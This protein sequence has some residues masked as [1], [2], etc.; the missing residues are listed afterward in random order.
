MSFKY[1]QTFY[2]DSATVQGSIEAS[3]SGIGLYFRAKP[4]FKNNKS[5]IEGPG[6]EVSLVPV[7]GGIP[8]IQEVGTI[9][10]PEPTE[11]G[12]RFAPR[13]EVARKEWG[14]ITATADASVETKFVFDEPIQLKTKSEYGIVIK[15]DG[16]EDY[17]FWGSR[18]GNKLVGTTTVSP[19]ASN[20]YVG[21]LFDYISHPNLNINNLIPSADT[22]NNAAVINTQTNNIIPT[23]TADGKYSAQNWKP[24][25]DV[26]LKFKVYASRYFHNGYPVAANVTIQAD[27][28]YAD[29]FSSDLLPTLNGNVLTMVA[30]SIPQE[31][32]R[33]DVDNSVYH[34]IQAGDYVCQRLPYYPSTQKVPLT[35]SVNASSYVVTAN[36]SFLYSNGSTFNNANGFNNL[37]TQ[38]AADDE[39]I[40][41]EGV[42]D[43]TTVIDIRKVVGIIANSQILVDRPMSFTNGASKFWKSPVG[44]IAGLNS[45]YINGQDTAILILSDSNANGTLRFTNN[46]IE[47]SNIVAGG[48]GYSN[49]DYVT[50][51]GYESTTSVTGG[52]NA[53]LLLTT[54]STGG[55]VN[56]F[57]A[58]TGAGFVY[59]SRLVG[60][61]VVFSNSTGGTS[62]GSGANLQFNIGST[63]LAEKEPNFRAV[64]CAIINL[65]AARLKPEITVNN[66][67]GSTFVV[68]HRSL[69]YSQPNTSV[70]NGKDAFVYAAPSS[71]DISV[72]IF[73]SHD[74]GKEETYT[75]IVPSRSNEFI[76]PYANGSTANTSVIGQRYSNSSV[77]LFDVSANNDYLSPYIEPKII[78]SHYSKYVINN[79]YTNE[80]TNY[81]NA[82]AKH[83]TTKVNFNKDRSAEDILVYLTAYRPV[84]TDFK[85]Y[86][87]IHSNIDVDAFDDKD[88][89]LLE[90]IDGIGVYSSKSDSSDFIELTYNFQ[91]TANTTALAGSVTV[92]NVTTTTITG[93]GTNF[94]TSL[95]TKDLVKITNPLFSGNSYVFCVVNT[96]TNNTS[97][98]IN[99]P[100]SNTGLV[101]SGMQIGKVDYKFQ[102]F[103]NKLNSNI[104]QYFDSNMV[105]TQTYDTFQVKVV[106]LSNS[107]SIVPKIDDIRTIGVSA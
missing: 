90:Q 2:L 83:V 23:T 49:N 85:V 101:G 54:N 65:E 52:Y 37:Y 82:Y 104:V 15:V 41:I 45:T 96:V 69:F 78:H 47:S 20:K 22:S 42:I 57:V 34:Q 67:L 62:A 91:D 79:D 44:T 77:Y 11:H 14:E 93:S 80:H 28:K 72:K 25:A 55:I 3:I 75:S 33:I 5:G 53:K 24:I 81:G 98:T 19:G 40:I 7:I 105:E 1:V 92:D 99:A 88:W 107:D 4:N 38:T 31:Y 86:A 76:I 17:V 73:K 71:T 35:V 27:P 100:I 46:I 30:P 56:T 60:S 10:P 16:S 106:M 66:P 8:Q 95:V 21:N 87:R 39:Y 74:V 13:N 48:T 102:A 51:S 6:V 63:M 97:F 58:N 29:R 26:D 68:R 61:N 32:I 84:G 70:Y 59:P 50:I 64:N 43:G 36:S 103:N 9:R 89:T 94:S 18:Q 12:A